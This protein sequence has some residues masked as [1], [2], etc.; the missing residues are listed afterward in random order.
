VGAL[1]E[2]LQ[3]TGGVVSVHEALVDLRAT[4]VQLRLKGARTII[5][6]T[7]IGDV[8]NVLQATLDT[9][10]MTKGYSY[11]FTALVCLFVFLFGRAGINLLPGCTTE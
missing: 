3:A 5:V 4:F 9:G 7:G 10:M 1:A 11:F 8:N 2:S 6:D